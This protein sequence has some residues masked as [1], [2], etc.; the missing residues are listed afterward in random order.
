[1]FKVKFTR[2]QRDGMADTFDKI[3][4][5]GA[6]GFLVGAFV[7]GKI[8]I[9]GGFLLGLITVVFVAISVILRGGGGVEK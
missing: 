9:V 8:T 5:A 4:Q 7:E 3:G 1:M 2:K 6:I